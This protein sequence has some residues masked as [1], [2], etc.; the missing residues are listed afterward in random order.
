LDSTFQSALDWLFGTQNRGVKLGLENIRTLL[1]R[2]GA[3]ERNQRFI[4]VAGTNGKGSVCAMIESVCRASGLITGLFT[5]PHL[6]HFNERI[7]VC[8][9][10]IRNDD[11]VEGL[12]R[13]RRLIDTENHPTFF[14]ITTALAFSYFAHRAVDVVILETG[15][16]GRL[17]ATN[18][19]HPLVSVLTSIDLDHQQWLGNTRAEIAAEKAGIIK[20]G[21]PVLSGPQLPEVAQVIEAVAARTRS[22]LTY[23][24]EPITD[25]VVRLPGSHQHTNAALAVAAAKQAGFP[26]H[27]DAVIRG[28]NTVSWPGRFQIAKPDVVLD[29]A[30]NAPA[31]RQ[32]VQ[33]WTEVMGTRSCT[34][35]FGGLRDK[36][37][38]AMASILEGIAT[39][40]ILV[41]VR[42]Q[43]SVSSSELAEMV[44]VQRPTFHVPT[45]REALE[46]A[47]AS[48]DPILVTGSLFL[49]GETLAL[50]QGDTDL[51]PPSMQ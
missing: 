45:V 7:Q 32:L 36:Q 19:V 12:E 8:G 50:L 11:V 31:C 10:P 20:P 49:V 15:L 4:H 27:R 43:R 18:V 44:Q 38:G 33:T 17:D 39:R 25:I 16:G 6:V 28:L 41:P 35:I 40:F 46:L 26:V 13:I 14:E 37:L 42:S 2:M 48:Q 1:S 22:P 23:V 5:S 30:H 51:D 3:P 9:R 34:V 24:T 29:G 21:V 47:G